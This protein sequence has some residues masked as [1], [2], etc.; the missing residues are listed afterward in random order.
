MGFFNA[1]MTINL[2]PD[3]IH[4]WLAW[5]ERIQDAAL[6]RHYSCLLD[7]EEYARWQRI[8]IPRIQHEYLIAH[9]LLR[10]S[11]SRY[12]PLPPSEWSFKR[13]QYGRPEIAN[14][15]FQS[16]RFNLSHT[17]GL[18]A[19]ALNLKHPIGVDVETL[20][21]SNRLLDIADRYF[22]AQECV[23]LQNLPQTQQHSRFF[24]YWTLKESFIKA[25]GMGLALPLGQF[26]FKFAEQTI[27]L[28]W[29]DALQ[30]D[31]ARWAFWLYRLGATHKLALCCEKQHQSCVSLMP[32]DRA[33]TVLAKFLGSSEHAQTL[34]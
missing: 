23:D 26:G 16:L 2:D 14:P 1:C 32:F 3:A 9:A 20:D 29:S 12:A 5:P 11:L 13:N 18:V 17:Q 24:D 30:D 25:K 10:L 6:L 21:R 34:A 31:P 8:K 4:V 28:Y 33:N 7:A 15:G 19:C 27:R 22:S